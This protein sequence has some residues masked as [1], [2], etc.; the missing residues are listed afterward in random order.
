MARRGRRPHRMLHIGSVATFLAKVCSHNEN[1]ARYAAAICIRVRPE[2]VHRAARG[3]R[4]SNPASAARCARSRG[5][6][7]PS[8][9]SPGPDAPFVAAFNQRL[10]EVGLIEGCLP[11]GLGRTDDLPYRAGLY[12]LATASAFFIPATASAPVISTV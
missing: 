12:T 7:L 10:K 6:R 5:H 4:D 11:T 1:P 8:L 9:S 3:T 2:R